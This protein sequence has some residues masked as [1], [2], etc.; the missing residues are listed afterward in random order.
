MRTASTSCLDASPGIASSGGFKY[1]KVR[2]LFA[3]DLT[4]VYSTPVKL[5]AA[6]APTVAPAAPTVKPAVSVTVSGVTTTTTNLPTADLVTIVWTAVTT[7]Y[8][9]ATDGITGY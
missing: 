3:G 2:G 7:G 4:G 5:W 9:G 8:N 1:Y 6:G